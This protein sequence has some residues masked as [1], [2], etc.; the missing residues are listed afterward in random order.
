M[1]DIS[2]SPGFRSLMQEDHELEATFA[3]MVRSCL[4]KKID[5]VNVKAFGLRRYISD[6]N[7]NVYSS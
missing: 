3:Y 7:I 4:K 5:K 1:M 6:L 2:V